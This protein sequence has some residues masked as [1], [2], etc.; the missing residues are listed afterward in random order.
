MTPKSFEVISRPNVATLMAADELARYE[1]ALT[2][3]VGAWNGHGHVGS[4]GA[5]GHRGVTQFTERT[6]HL[7]AQDAGKRNE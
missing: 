1:A 7:P 2:E 4:P 5:H 3:F 6:G